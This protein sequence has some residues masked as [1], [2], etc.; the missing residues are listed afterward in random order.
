MVLPPPS[1]MVQVGDW[2]DSEAVK[3]RVTSSP[4]LALPVPPV[5]IDTDPRVGA[6]VSSTYVVVETAPAFPAASTILILMLLEPLSVTAIDTPVPSPVAWSS[7]V[8]DDPALTDISRTSPD[9]RAAL[10]VAVTV[11]AVSYTHLT[12]PTKRIV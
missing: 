11:W 1:L 10:R 5:E 12:L 7:S 6:V 4:S 2:I 8:H 3:L 9:A